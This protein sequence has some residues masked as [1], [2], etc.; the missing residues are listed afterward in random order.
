MDLDADTLAPALAKVLS[1]WRAMKPPGHKEEPSNDAEPDASEAGMQGD[2]LLELR[3]SDDAPSGADAAE[4]AAPAP[5]FPPSVIRPTF[6]QRVHI[7]F[8]EAAPLLLTEGA[9]AAPG[10]KGPAAPTAQADLFFSPSPARRRL[11]LKPPADA[12]STVGGASLGAQSLPPRRGRLHFTAL[13]EEPGCEAELPAG[14]RDVKDLPARLAA[15]HDK[16][17]E[18]L[19]SVRLRLGIS[20]GPSC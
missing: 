14:G 4:P 9:K 18:R 3:P 5:A 17:Q 13:A 16:L 2:L 1:R 19:A 7:A 15:E 8:D 6:G 12:P 11:D 20:A 10:S